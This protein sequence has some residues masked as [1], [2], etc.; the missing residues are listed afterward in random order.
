M[1][2]A[3]D[4]VSNSGGRLGKLTDFC[5]TPSSLYNTPMVVL[6]TEAGSVP[7]LTQDVVKLVLDSSSKTEKLLHKASG[8]CSDHLQS[9]PLL[10]V[11]IQHFAKHTDTLIK[12]GKGVAAFSGLPSL[13]VLATIQSSFMETRSGFTERETVSTWTRNGR[14][15]LKPDSYM[16]SISSLHS[17]M[18]EALHDADT[19][20]G[21]PTKRLAKSLGNSMAHLTACL[22]LAASTKNVGSALAPLLGGWDVQQRRRWA[23]Q[24]NDLQRRMEASPETASDDT[25]AASTI[26]GFTLAGLHSNGSTAED[27]HHDDPLLRDIVKA[28]LEGVTDSLPRIAMG[29]YSPEVVLQLVSLGLDVLDSSLAIRAAD[30][31]A[32]LTFPY[33]QDMQNRLQENNER[34][35]KESE[36]DLNSDLSS[37]AK[38]LTTAPT[39]KQKTVSG[40][41]VTG[42]QQSEV[43]TPDKCA[44]SSTSQTKHYEINLLENRQRDSSALLVHGCLCYTCSSGYTRSYLHHLSKSKEMLAPVLLSIH[45]LHHWLG[46]F[47]SIRLAVASDTLPQL[48]DMVVSSRLEGRHDTTLNTAS[49]PLSITQLGN[50]STKKSC[51]A[52]AADTS[53]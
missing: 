40:C 23:R 27:L 48:Q 34:L 49:P 36:S 2:F 50:V 7:N 26:G 43:D 18:F 30:R 1:K 39:K 15:A 12:Y 3:I 19:P 29:S 14:V 37:V 13:G 20:R 31:L 53:G 33:T 25:A 4:Y 47:S 44:N 51:N 9:T 10:S 21:C 46:F 8:Q 16:Q 6:S 28:S 41:A 35:S 24:L 22:E 45:N 17:D 11:P 5:S 52:A 38:V 32:A 42:Q